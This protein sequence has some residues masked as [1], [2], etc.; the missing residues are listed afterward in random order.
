MK[1]SASMNEIFSGNI[2]IDISEHINRY[3]GLYFPESRHHALIKGIKAAARELGFDQTEKFIDH[4]LSGPPSSRTIDTLVRFL[5]IGETY[6]FR[7]KAVFQALKDEIFRGLLTQSPP[8]KKHVHIWSAGCAS[9][10]EPYSIAILMDQMSAAFRG[11]TVNILGTDINDN[12]LEKAKK[13]VYTNW[14][15]RDTPDIILKKY[16]IPQKDNSFKLKAEIKNRV[17]FY[18]LNLMETDYSP[19]LSEY[20]PFDI[21]FCRNVI[22][23]F[24][25]DTQKQV[26][27]R[28]GRYIKQDGWLITSPA[29]SGAVSNS[30][31][32]PV[33]FPN[34]IC[35]RKGLPRLSEK[36]HYFREPRG[37]KKKG[38]RCRVAENRTKTIKLHPNRRKTDK[39]FESGDPQKIY[40]QALL[41]YQAGQYME[42]IDRLAPLV[43]ERFF[44]DTG[45]LMLPESLD[46]LARAYA[47]L[48]DLE[49]AEQYCRKA[50]LEEPLNPSHY[51]LLGTIHQEAGRF[52]DAIT[53]FKQAIYL[54]PDMIMGHFTLSLAMKQAGKAKEAERHLKITHDLLQKTDLN[55]I[56]PLSEWLTAG[57]L[58]DTVLLLLKNGITS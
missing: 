16:F 58:L 41:L 23:Y 57:R 10:E 15:F 45:F 8:E 35:H 18:K 9:G 22:M 29:E 43:S 33:H 40:S 51:F 53:A 24:R 4:L 11:W 17:K 46:L 19:Y 13:G 6:F 2:C 25:P 54:D 48:N 36:P 38:S 55:E 28:I 42:V 7:D 5:T 32:V 47:N 31:F 50:I 30:G 12:L 14:S 52:S 56:I 1:D 26:V 37:R 44:P 27:V 39:N 34:A 21:V 49:K 20:S 3:T